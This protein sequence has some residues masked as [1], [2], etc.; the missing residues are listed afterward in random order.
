MSAA[1]RHVFPEGLLAD[2]H[3]GGVHARRPGQALE[4]A[5]VLDDG[6]E[7][8]LLLLDLR[9]LGLHLERLL[10]GCGVALDQVGDVARQLVHLGERH[11]HHPRH[12]LDGALR[13]QR[14][15]GN[16][17][18]HVLAP[19]FL[20]DVVDDLGPP[21]LAEVH[22]EVGHGHALGIQEPLEEQVVRERIDVGDA[23]RVRNQRPGPGAAARADGN[24][25]RLRPIDEVVDDE[26]IPGE[27]HCS[28]DGQLALEPLAVLVGIDLPAGAGDLR[29]A[30]VEP[31]PR[32]PLD[33][34]V[35]RLTFWH[36]E[37]GKV[38]AD[39]VQLDVAALGD[40][41]RVV[42]RLAP[43]APDAGGRLGGRRHLLRS[44]DVELLRLVPQTPRVVEG[45]ARGDGH[46][47]LVRLGVLALDVVAVRRRDERDLQ[48]LR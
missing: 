16:D 3:A 19:V 21:V 7:D 14:A 27:L 15:V 30:L 17:L 22:V 35:E 5:R 20:R 48:I 36:L 40:E 33:V 13:R 42:H 1:E 34:R 12:V 18:R 31:L 10:D 6:P 25:V 38:L 39:E 43:F 32:A 26:E 24:A 47:H 29:E 9:E 4:R 37:L 11:A 28:D 41:G 46:Q 2:D 23:Q 44:L 8:R 45:A